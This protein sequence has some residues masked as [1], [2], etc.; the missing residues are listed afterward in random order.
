LTFDVWNETFREADKKLMYSP[1]LVL[2]QD[3]ANSE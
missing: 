3:V 2:K 1:Y